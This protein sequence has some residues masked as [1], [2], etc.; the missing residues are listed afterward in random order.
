MRNTNST[1][2]IQT[3]SVTTE[4]S[5]KMR[6][7]LYKT[8]SRERIF[9]SIEATLCESNETVF[10]PDI[11]GNEAKATRI[12]DLIVQGTVTPCCMFEVIEDLIE[13]LS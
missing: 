11:T 5:L 4:N 6:Y 13:S 10:V 7:S 8:T 1:N 12:F 9:Y 3:T 2:I